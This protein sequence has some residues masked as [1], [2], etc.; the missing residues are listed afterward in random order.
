MTEGVVSANPAYKIWKRQDKLIYS[1]LIGAISVSVQPLLSRATTAADVW[2][3][4]MNTYANPSRSHVQQLR[5]QLK[6]WTKG[7]K[8]I[9]EYVQ[10]FITR[11][12]KLALLEKPIEYEDQIEYVLDGLT[13]EYKS[14]IDQIGGR[15]RTPTLTEVHEKLLNHEVKLQATVIN[16]SAIPVTANVATYQ[17]QGSNNNYRGNSNNYRRQNKNSRS[18]YRN[19]NLNNQTWQQQQQFS[20]RN[21]QFTPRGYQGRCQICGIHGHSARTCY[22]LQSAS[23]GQFTST[24]APWQPHANLATASSPWLLDSGSTHHLTTDLNNLSMHQL[25]N[26]G[27]K[28]TIAD[29]SGLPI[30]HT[31]LTSLPTPTRSLT[32]NNVLYVPNLHKNLISVYRL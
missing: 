17:G 20:P 18:F 6:Q 31:G 10:G 15:E 21:D 22:Q 27:E 19:N 3:T 14:V 26:G 25:Y 32:L 4:L 9:D 11:F 12:D 1:A 13:E 30:S 23:T 8:T 28:V 5:Q 16:S 29:G 24:P 2:S 7:T